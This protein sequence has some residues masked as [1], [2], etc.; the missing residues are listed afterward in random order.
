MRATGQT[1]VEGKLWIVEAGRIRVHEP[2]V[3]E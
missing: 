1:S 3:E 2:D